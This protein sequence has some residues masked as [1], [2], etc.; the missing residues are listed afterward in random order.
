[1][2]AYKQVG[3]DAI[4]DNFEFLIEAGLG[5]SPFSDVTLDLSALMLGD[6]LAEAGLF[7]TA[8]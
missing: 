7:A 6:F 1:V 8:S 4:Y 2:N 3:T 5:Q